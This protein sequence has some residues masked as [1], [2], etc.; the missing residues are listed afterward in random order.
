MADS[1]C[2]P[3]NRRLG[4]EAD[5][6][7]MRRIIHVIRSVSEE[8]APFQGKVFLGRNGDIPRRSQKAA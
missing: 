3:V 6:L 8:R 1:W 7:Q 4:E 5:F 2:K